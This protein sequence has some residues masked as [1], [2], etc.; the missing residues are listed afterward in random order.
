MHRLRNAQVFKTIVYN[1]DLVSFQSFNLRLA[2]MTEEKIGGI[3]SPRASMPHAKIIE[4]GF[5]KEKTKK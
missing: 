2:Q 3:S 1:K 5:S 4:I